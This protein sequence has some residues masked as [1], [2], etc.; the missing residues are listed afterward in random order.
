MLGPALNA[1][2]TAAI[3]VG[4]LCFAA[5]VAM[6]AP[7][8][9]WLDSSEF[10][11]ASFVLGVAHP[12]GHPLAALVG[13]LFALLPVG[14]VAL[15]VGLSQAACGAVAAA[16]LTLIAA[17]LARRVGEALGRGD[18]VVEALAGAAA[19][20]GFGLG[21]AAA[22]Q[23]VRPE[24]YALHAAIA[25]AAVWMLARF[26]RDG[27][28]RRLL[29]ASLALGLGLA[30]HHFLAGL[31]GIAAVLFVA[32]Q[33]RRVAAVGAFRLVALAA[34]AALLGALVYA[35]LPLRALRHPSVDWGA[36]STLSRFVWTVSARAFQ[37]SLRRAEPGGGLEVVVA[38]GREL[39]LLGPL[40]L[41]GAWAAIRVRAARPLALLLVLGAA[42][43]AAAPALVGFDPDNPDAY[44]YLEVAVGLL[45]ALSAALPAAVAALSQ[46][47]AAGRAVACCIAAIAAAGA[48]R[49]PA[50]SLARFDDTATVAGEILEET[51][52]R[53]LL[54]TSYYQTV[55]PLWYLRAVEGRRPDVDHV[56][57]HFL[58]WPG[59]RE[60]VLLHRSTLAPLLGRRDVDTE[61]L[62]RFAARRPV[63]VE[64]DL[65]L[66]PALVALLVPGALVDAVGP[67]GAA[68][69]RPAPLDGK[70]DLGEPETRRFVF[71]RAF[72]DAHRECS[73]GRFTD[74][75]AAIARARALLGGTPD[76]DLEELARRC[77]G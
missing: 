12:P 22:M 69:A 42:L 35:Y 63:L 34:G 23:A 62:R 36:P 40:V 31:V 52:P 46:R 75:Q 71:W 54:V 2:R 17:E 41:A 74:G 72:L 9:Y 10:A 61:A 8:A 11:A 44:G 43:E 24:V 14:S 39:W 32:M 49:L 3:A 73:T 68:A 28:P 33:Y 20:L 47:K 76:P 5:Y 6:A 18:E 77:G 60:D 19:G 56:H 13:K 55:F 67:W 7:G 38:L 45:C 59:Y 50:L 58:A 70:L 16:L 37:R 25:L 26:D 51:P 1:H 57:R 66:D 29:V 4:F 15:R 30:N 48:V 64:Y 53:A 65:D 21:H 27:D